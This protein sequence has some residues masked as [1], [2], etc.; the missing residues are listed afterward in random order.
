[1]TRLIIICLCLLT[2]GAHAHRVTPPNDEID[3]AINIAN[4]DAFCS[5]DAKYSNIEATTTARGIPMN[6]GG[7]IG[8]DVW[9]KF[10]ATKFDV[11]ITVN[12]KDNA[13]STNTL[14]NPL[15][16]IYTFDPA[17]N[18]SAELPTTMLTSSNVSSITKNGLTP[19]TVYYIRVSAAMNAEGTF[20]L[21]VN[22]YFAPLKPGQDCSTVSI[23][24]KMEEFTQT[25]VAGAGLKNTETAGTCLG[26]ESNS[27]WYMW[28]AGKNGTFTFTITP[29]VRNNDIDWVLYDLGPGGDCSKVTAANAIRC[30]SGSGVTCTPFYNQ[31]GLS[32]TETDLRE[33]LGCVPGQNGFV[34]YVDMIAGHNY[35]LIVDNFSPGNNGFHI[36]FGG[37][38][39]F[40]GPTAEIKMDKINPCTFQQSYTFTSLSS[41]YNT[42]K[43]T[44]GEGANIATAN[45]EGPFNITYATPGEKAVVLEAKGANGCTVFSTVKFMVAN[46]PSPPVI[47]PSALKLCVG[48][49]L[50]LST[51]D[52][53]LATYHWTGPNGFTSDQQ[54]P[55]IVITGPE[56]AGDYQLYVQVGDCVSKVTTLTIPPIYLKPEAQFKIVSNNACQA[57]QSFTL[58]NQ[59]ANFTTATWDA[60]AGV[61]TLTTASNGD[62]TL[63]YNTTGT[64]TITLTVQNAN[65]CS[66]S[67]SQQ[68]E[69]QLKP[70][71]PVITA[72][73]TKF[74]IGETLK[75]SV[76]ATNLA[77][78]HWTGPNGFTSDQQ[79]PEV[80]ITGP[81]NAGDY[82]LYVQV[83]D[84]A[85]DVTTLSIPPIYLK[86]EAQFK[87][88]SNNVCQ[89]N[90]SFTLVNQST[91]FA[92]A[93]WDAGAGVKTLTTASNGD[94]TL[95]YNTT[96]TKTITLTVQNANGCS[97]SISQQL[98]VQ[99]KPATPVITANQTK[100]C[101]GDV[102]KLEVDEVDGVAYQW[103]GPNGFTANTAKIEVP[104]TD[105]KQAGTYQ[106]VLKA[107]DCQSDAVQFMVPPIAKIPVAIFNTEPQFNAKF[108][109]PL[110][111]VFT[112]NSKDADSY[113]W[114]FGDGSQSTLASP[115]H[116]YTQSG[117]FKITLTA[118]ADEGCSNSVTKGDLVILKNASLFVPNAFSPN[119]DGTNDEFVVS[120]T[121]L[122]KYHL[123]IYSR[124]G[125]NLFQTTSI[126]ENWN[127]T[128]NNKPV[129]VGVYFYVIMGKN[130]ANQDVKYTGSLTLIR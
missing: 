6:W 23:L 3:K 82:Q 96:G 123:F 87:I 54:N 37:T 26:T 113:L 125:E 42:L 70:A 62:G 71:T 76:P 102:M 83:G 21:C 89:A 60:G 63:T 50:K 39:E 129:P 124:L 117:T 33:E 90:Q 11:N 55:E 27:A 15:V 93:I 65:G 5:E 8:K 48:E 12:G 7:A 97:V 47:T 120:I 94:G 66:V 10:T 13:A 43:W 2:L 115:T 126:F 64:K 59:S 69:V 17:T 103:T 73:Q 118:Y 128:Y 57:N 61:K 52:L 99:L 14:V 122:K 119:G 30:A 86:P 108:S 29:T 67:I 58:V 72:N 9:F 34:K 51:P 107:G 32:L 85:S 44:F 105:F 101:I 98:E 106:I 20:K 104:L 130:I 35:A 81:E 68:L 110:P 127:G 53:D 91:N 109:A 121:N 24:C 100:F 19:G 41:N 79:N 92:T 114:D 95:T 77:T 74:C 49:T 38:T 31:T 111:I 80:V 36:Q 46:T 22:N 45:T 56:N 116:T 25:N 28:T 88:V 16:A 40:V 84:C 78:Y 1:M 4:T 18:S 75:L 112:N